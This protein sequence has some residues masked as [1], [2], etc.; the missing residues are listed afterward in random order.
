MEYMAS[1]VSQSPP[2]LRPGQ[3][4]LRIAKSADD[5]SGRDSLGEN[6]AQN[7]K[8]QYTD[9]SPW[10]PC[11]RQSEFTT[12][13]RV[14]NGGSKSVV[15]GP[16]ISGQICCLE[17]ESGRAGQEG[18]G[19]FGQGIVHFV[20]HP[21]DLL[22]AWPSLGPRQT[23]T[24]KKTASHRNIQLYVVPHSALTGS[25][26]PGN[27][28]LGMQAGRWRRVSLALLRNLSLH[29]SEATVPLLQLTGSLCASLLELPALGL[30]LIPNLTVGRLRLLHLRLV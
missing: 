29:L 22:L 13:C 5:V 26:V 3:H 2:E 9:P 11:H 16:V 28:H 17:V 24:K 6:R 19:P 14:Q 4:A 7:V 8:F 25:E 30:Q 12:P 1:S 21:R 15:G 27:V 23:G 10:R 20:T 18:A